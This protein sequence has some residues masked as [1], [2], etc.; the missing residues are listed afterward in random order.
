MKSIFSGTNDTA[1]LD[2]V[3]RSQ[4]I[5]E[6][7]PDGTI[8]T[9]NANFLKAIGYSLKEI[10][11]KHHSL[12]V[13][14]AFAKSREY[15]SFWDSL[16]NGKYQAG[17]F[18]RIGKG[19]KEIW[20]QATYSPVFN[21]QGKTVRVVKVAT[22]VT[23]QKLRQSEFEGQIE[24]INKSQAV[25]HFALD[26]TILH[27]NEN[28][29]K[30]L[31]YSLDEIKSKH[32]S[33]F[34]DPAMK[35]SS[36]YRAF[37]QDLSQGKFKAGEFKRLG[38]GGKQVWIQASYNPI[39]DARGRPVKVVKLAT[40][41]TAQVLERNR[42]ASVQSTIDRSLDE[43]VQSVSAA[44][45]QSTDSANAAVQTATNVQAVA[46]A[47]EEL[48]ASIQEITRQVGVAME[49]AREAVTEASHSNTIMAGLSEDAQK[50]GNIIEL[51][52][53]IANQTNLLALN[54][55]IE[56]ARAGEAGKGFAVVASE[57][58]NLAA[59]TSKATE[60][61]SAQIV[62]VQGTAGNAVSSIEKIIAIIDRISEISTTISSA[63]EEQSAV[64]QDIS[65]NMHAASAGVELVTGT[66][67]SVSAST[68]EIEAA[69][70]RV[71]EAS[72]AIA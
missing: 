32:H 7:L 71:R 23:E 42:R 39:F 28:F 19:G 38:K 29:L 11:G 27:A 66:V 53:N 65:S 26:G 33:L 57:V 49:V 36:E 68:A 15:K 63:V 51:I 12:F 9:A 64:T 10:T 1:T 37:W 50:I 5:I 8:L 72:R 16:A 44:F 6:F 22:D 69:T 46:A 62:S 3:S 58:K 35:S 60:E 34:I 25:I 61:I 21:R 20:I 55:T 52:D 30:A 54:A 18:M 13:D 4:A 2:A 17:E 59:Q 31:G 14:P 40:D 48:V 47:A 24:A 45:R 70:Q 43:V 56:A 67:Q 41:V